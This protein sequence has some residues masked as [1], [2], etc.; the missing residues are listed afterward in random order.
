M[1]STYLSSPRRARLVPYDVRARRGEL[2]YVLVTLSPD[3]DLM[4]RF[5]LRSTESLPQVE[6]GEH[7]RVRGV[8]GG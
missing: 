3:G 4:A 2:K 6:R 8:Q 1:T 7:V 5:V